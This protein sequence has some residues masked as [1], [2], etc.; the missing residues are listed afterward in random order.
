M[1][2]YDG[3]AAE[4]DDF[5][6]AQKLLVAQGGRPDVVELSLDRGAVLPSGA[7]RAA[8]HGVCQSKRDAAVQRPDRVAVQG[9]DGDFGLRVPVTDSGHSDADGVCK[10][11]GG[12]IGVHQFFVIHNSLLIFE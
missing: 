10:G 11:V 9:S 7:R 2:N 5:G 4:M 6:D 8:G 1:Q 3:L 12:V